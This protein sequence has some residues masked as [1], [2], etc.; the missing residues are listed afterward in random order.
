VMVLGIVLISSISLKIVCTIMILMVM[1]PSILVI[2]S[3]QNIMK[4]SLI[5]VTSTEIKPLMSVKSTIVLSFVKTNGE[6]NTAQILNTSTV[7][8]HTT[9]LNVME[10]GIVK[11]STISPWTSWLTM[12]LIMM[13]ISILLIPSMK[14]ITMNS[15]P[16]VIITVTDLSILVKLTNVLSTLKTPGEMN[17]AQTMVMSIVTVHSSLLMTA[18][19]CGLVKISTISPKIPWLT[20]I[21]M[22]MVLP[23]TM[24]PSIILKL[25][26]STT[27]VISMVTEKPISVKSTNVLSTMKTL[28]DKKIAQ[29]TNSS[30]VTAHSLLLKLVMVLGLVM[31]STIS[32]VI[33]YTTMI[34]MVMVLLI[35]KITSMKLT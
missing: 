24:M 30:I 25:M 27:T 13:E 34:L 33:S 1:V 29:V 20:M 35:G 6:I 28:G 26:N 9:F 23:I 4:S 31:I 19:V 2:T 17:T 10:L 16:N 18:Q 12:I 21:L 3:N 7:I 32:P 5:T 15:K 22:V 8:A 11:I 14:V